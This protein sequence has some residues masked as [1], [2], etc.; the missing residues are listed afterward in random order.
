MWY[1]VKKVMKSFY[2]KASD[3]KVA[4]LF[5]AMTEDFIWYGQVVTSILQIAATAV[6]FRLA[7]GAGDLSFQNVQGIVKMI[8]KS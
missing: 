2:R 7:D 8:L 1:N 5:P 3:E 6:V 4:L